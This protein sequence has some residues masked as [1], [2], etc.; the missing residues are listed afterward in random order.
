MR[1]LMT[2][3][4]DGHE[5]AA[6]V[7]GGSLA[8]DEL[9]LRARMLRGAP[10]APEVIAALRRGDEGLPEDALRREQIDRLAEG[11]VVVCAGQQPGIFGGPTLTLAKAAAAVRL[12]TTLDSE[13][14]PAVPLFWAA[15][16]D[17][18]FREAARYFLRPGEGRPEGGFFRLDER[19]VDH[20]LHDTILTP[21]D[22]DRLKDLAA[23]E[24][25]APEQLPREDE[26]FGTWFIR[27][28]AQLTA[29]SGLVIVEPAWFAA[30]LRPFRRRILEARDDL[31]DLMGAATEA[32]SAAGYATPLAP[33]GRETSFLFLA[34]DRG[35]R[36]LDAEPPGWRA[37]SIEL[38]AEELD[39]I[40]TDEPRRISS[41]A[42]ARPLA[43]QALFPVAAQIS[44]PTEGAYMAQVM[45]L[46]GAL[47]LPRP[48]VRPRPGLLVVDE[49]IREQARLAGLEGPAAS[50]RLDPPVA[51]PGAVDELLAGLRDLLDGV[52]NHQDPFL[53][54]E[55]VG[56]RREV[57][58]R[59]RD[60]RKAYQ[61]D[62]KRR[63][64]HR[65]RALHRLDQELRPGRGGQDRVVGI[66][67]LG[68]PFD[69]RFFSRLT[70]ALGA[71]A[72]GK[73][74]MEARSDD[75]RP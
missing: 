24:G 39:R 23:R 66:P 62:L 2:E 74:T 22:L 17:H 28:L 30:E 29:G 4:L 20:S 8:R 63:D 45:P 52:E 68:L 7:L 26:S 70:A 69:G 25:V 59:L 27:L 10:T 55:L 58:G 33:P 47:G 13:G 67:A 64:R 21:E 60:L 49:D 73:V 51:D 50:W 65:A 31:V 48:L 44:G 54:R 14:I 46:F 32:L 56:Y 12:A 43:Q 37:G 15:S 34:T 36:R 41:A 3:L 11:A 40:I 71:E 18:D 42:A 35:R 16:E 38:G 75:E 9:L 61:R 53:R 57:T 5:E 19:R 1:T 72:L 6:R